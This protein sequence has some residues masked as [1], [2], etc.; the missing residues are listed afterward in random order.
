MTSA[1]TTAR[2]LIVGAG[3]VGLGAA[4]FLAREGVAVRLV[5][6][7]ERPSTHSKALA[8]N[9]RTLDL[10]ES[11]GVTKHMI[12]MGTPIRSAQFWYQNAT[13]AEL[14]F[15]TLRHRYPW[16][17]ALSQS[18]TEELLERALAAH[19]VTVER[20]V[21]LIRC[22]AQK[23]GASATLRL[24]SGEQ[25]S[26]T[27]PWLLAADGARSAVREQ[28][29]VDFE[30]TTFGRPWHL[31]DVPLS[32]ALPGDR[33]HVFFL[34]EGDFCSCCASNMIDGCSPPEIRCGGS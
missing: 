29:R 12:E 24:G 10:L 13:V 14:S 33:A 18:S 4:L 2:P 3:P 6:Q 7:A 28:L 17:L 26:V 8:V 16:M 20:G 22:V 34:E 31:A 30:G 27:C 11:T 9:P 23:D 21:A 5:D 15:S 1:A 25:E 19:G 32:T